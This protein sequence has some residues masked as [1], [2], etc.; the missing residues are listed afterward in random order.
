MKMMSWS[1]YPCLSKSL[2]RAERRIALRRCSRPATQP[3]PAFAATGTW[4]RLGSDPLFP[5]CNPAVSNLT[6]LV[7]RQE[8][9][10]KR[11]D[12]LGSI[13]SLWPCAGHFRSSPIS[14]RSQGH[15]HVS[16]VP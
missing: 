12:G 4:R 15:R 1:R 13:A 10:M 5:I 14:E 16:T 9:V 3:R 6:R 2:L 11:N 7:L 8:R